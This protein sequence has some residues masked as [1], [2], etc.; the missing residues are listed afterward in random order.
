MG[1][2]QPLSVTMAGGVAI[3]IE[4]DEARIKR[5]IETDYLDKSTDDLA[6]A[7]S[8]AK[9]AIKEK[10]P[11]SIGLLGNAADIVPKFAKNNITSS[12]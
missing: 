1:G 6:E 5:R 3:C 4:I 11:L 9:T 8:W 12:T 7:I 2:A 10:M